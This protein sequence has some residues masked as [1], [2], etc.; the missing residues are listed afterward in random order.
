MWLFGFRAD[1]AKPRRI[2]ARG[3]SESPPAPGAPITPAALG[4]EQGAAG[5]LASTYLHE[6][7]GHRGGITVGLQRVG[8]REER[9]WGGRRISWVGAGLGPREAGLPA[10]ARLDGGFFSPLVVAMVSGR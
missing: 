3:G 6:L 2:N 4:L 8:R 7:V 9:G 5:G 10:R 1:R